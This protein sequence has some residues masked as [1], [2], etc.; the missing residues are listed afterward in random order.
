MLAHT[1]QDRSGYLG[2]EELMMLAKRIDPDATPWKI[3]V[4]CGIPCSGVAAYSKPDKQ[5]AEPAT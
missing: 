3:Q 5:A 4:C 1:S 2:V